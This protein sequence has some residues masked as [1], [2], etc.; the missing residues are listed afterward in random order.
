ME[1]TADAVT[2]GPGKEETWG[3]HWDT[4]QA[5]SLASTREPWEGAVT[6]SQGCTSNIWPADA[7]I[8]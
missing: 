3:W 7:N 5:S 4:D 6:Y 8:H 2:W 1:S